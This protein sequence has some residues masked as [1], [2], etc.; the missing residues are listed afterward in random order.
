MCAAAWAE[1]TGDGCTERKAREAAKR[2]EAGCSLFEFETGNL[3]KKNKAVM[4]K[5]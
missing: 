5:P 4:V 2:K 1:F 3:A